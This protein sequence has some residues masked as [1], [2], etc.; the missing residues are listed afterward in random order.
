MEEYI[1]CP[2]VAYDVPLH[3]KLLSGSVSLPVLKPDIPQISAHFLDAVPRLFTFCLLA[4]FFSFVY[5]HRIY[6]S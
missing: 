6:G 3:C 4:I 1:S 5:Y 2:D